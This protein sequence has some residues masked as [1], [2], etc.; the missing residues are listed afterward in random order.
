MAA[1]IAACAAASEIVVS[2]TVRDLVMGS[3]L[4]FSGGEWHVL[5]GLRDEWRLY[6]VCGDEH[7]TAYRSAEAK[8]SLPRRCARL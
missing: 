7:G 5:K 1:R 4:R 3:G 8:P 6:R 2:G